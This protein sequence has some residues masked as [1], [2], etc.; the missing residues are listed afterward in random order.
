MKVIILR[1]NLLEALSSVERGVGENVNLPILKNFLIKAQGGDIV[2]VSTNLEIAVEYSTSGKVLEGGELVVPFSVFSSVVRN[3]NS[4]RIT[5]EGRG[6]KILVSSDNYEGVIQDGDPKEFPIIP[7]VANRKQNIKIKTDEFR[8]VLRNSSISVQYSAIRPEIS[9]V[10]LSQSDGALTFVGTDSFRLSEVKIGDGRFEST[11]EDF[12]LIMPIRTVQEALRM[13]GGSDEVSL[14]VDSNQV[15]IESE[16]EKII[17]RTIDGSFPDYKSIVP[18]GF[19]TEVLLDKEEF[20]N[21]IKLVGTFSGKANDIKLKAGENGKFLEVFSSE[22]SVGESRYN[23]PAKIKGDEFTTIFNWKYLLDGLRIYGGKEISLN[24]NSPD[25]A[26][27]IASPKEQGT[28][29]I[30]MPIRG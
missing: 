27:E 8:Y 5:V 10:Y 15:L 22:S 24:L 3:L 20:A 19:K 2:F 4:E 30:V 6:G 11:L 1:T 12:S 17:S 26:A 9:G 14:F 28:R 7:E 16:K 23:I 29:Y 21:A 13:F 25:K 18:K